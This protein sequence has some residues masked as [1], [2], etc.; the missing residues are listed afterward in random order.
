MPLIDKKLTIFAVQMRASTRFFAFRPKP[1]RMRHRSF[2]FLLTMVFLTSVFSSCWDNFE[3][4]YFSSANVKRFYFQQQDTCVGIQYYVFYV[5]QKNGLIFNADSLPYGRT[6]NHLVP[7]MEFYSTN[8]ESSFNDTLFSIR[9]TLDFTLPVL[10]KNTSADGE[11]N[12]TYK[13]HVNVHQV[14]PT[15]LVVSTIQRAIP[16][17]STL[18]KSFR[19]SD[20]SFRLYFPLANGGFSAYQSDATHSSWSTLMVSGLANTMNVAS[21]QLHNDK[22]YATDNAGSLYVSTDGLAWS[23]QPTGIHIVTLYESMT[24]KELSDVNG[25]YLIGLSKDNAGFL[26]GIRSADGVTWEVGDALNADFPVSDYASVTWKSVTNK[27][28]VSVMTGLRAD[29][30]FSSS[31]WA[32]EDGL[33]W[34][35]VVKSSTLPIAN[36]KGSMVFYFED[37]LVCYGGIKPSGAYAKEMHISKDRGK[38]WINAPSNWVIP[39]LE[40]GDAYG[41]VQVE[42]IADTVND[43][44]RVFVWRLGGFSEGKKC[45]SLWKTFE[46]QAIFAH[47]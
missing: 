21:L 31:V 25:N 20:G 47:R 16:A 13:V 10:L 9:D 15:K 6:V 36:R 1:I 8:G 11:Y 45:H 35:L 14:D 34:I 41:S 2:V 43:K 33:Y 7:T 27:Q 32:T 46:Y 22:W 44:D 3:E 26:H 17:D 18:N 19:M 24:S 40:A 42:R 29:G 28:Y 4:M 12:R 30:A 38:T 5:D 37:E 39:A 23:V